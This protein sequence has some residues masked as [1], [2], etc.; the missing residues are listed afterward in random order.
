MRRP[1]CLLSLLVCA[2]WAPAALA[3]EK[4][5]VTD[6]VQRWTH[7]SG[8]TVYLIE[9]HDIPLVDFE[10][11]ARAGSLWD[12]V[13]KEGRAAA[14]AE[15]LLRGAGDRDRED[16]E[17]ELDLLG[18]DLEGDNGLISTTISGDVLA[19][20]L[21]PVMALLGDVI[22]RPRL[23]KSE[24][25]R[26]RR[27]MESDIL[28]TRDYDRALNQRFF[29]RY[30]MGTHPYGR[31][32]D[33]TLAGVKALKAEDLKAAWEE[34]FVGPNLIF[35]F[36]G[37]VSR[38]QVEAI[39]DTHFKGLRPGARAA[40]TLP[41]PPPPQ[42]RQVLLVDKPERTQN[43]I[44][45]GHLA[46]RSTHE[47][48][49]ALAVGNTLFGG[50]FTARLN[51]EVRDKRGL[52]YGAYST[53]EGDPFAGIFSMWTFPASE[54]AMKTIQL[55]ISLFEGLRAAPL[56]DDEVN[57][58]KEYLINSFAFRVDTPSKLLDESIRAD[59][60]GLPPDY[61]STY[62]PHIKAVTTAQVN[63]AIQRWLDPQNFL[64]VMLCTAAGFEEPA[65]AL[66]GVSSVRVVPHSA[67][68]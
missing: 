10:I 66:P 24:L 59:L 33:G 46:P 44:L 45:L 38:A 68:F 53:V 31:P 4:M 21:D 26:L 3:E 1:L 65:R 34:H 20:N 67:E 51:Q 57:F 36:A 56:T 22:L 19:R 6:H 52:S 32:E 13:G 17:E 14:L 55:L 40:L 58:S 37:D 64:L 12:P 43:Q 35:G 39:L 50:T 25:L 18:A 23:Q 27:E 9:R 49:Y 8:A 48:Q 2:L 41:E 63:A 15:L 30:L 11:T 16:L 61:L 29:E 7:A 5:N 60:L 54:D 28:Q 62:V 47:D 42:G